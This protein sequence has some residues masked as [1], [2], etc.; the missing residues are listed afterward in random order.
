MENRTIISLSL[1][2]ELKGCQDVVNGKKGAI[3]RNSTFA[4]DIIFMPESETVSKLSKELDVAYAE[5]AKYKEFE[6]KSTQ[7]ER[8]VGF[9]K[10]KIDQLESEAKKPIEINITENGKTN[11]DESPREYHRQLL[12]SFSKMSVWAFLKWRKGYRKSLNQ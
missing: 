12:I 11:G 10:K 9:Y 8:E 5:L 7:L 1:Y 6:A 2:D 3:I 4:R